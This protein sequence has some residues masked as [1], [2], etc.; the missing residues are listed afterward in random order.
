MLY[1]S[2]KRFDKN[3]DGKLKGAEWQRW[4]QYAYGD[5]IEAKEKRSRANAAAEQK[6]A[7]IAADFADHVSDLINW[8]YRDL[9]H[10]EGE[11]EDQAIRTMHLAL[12]V[13]SA[14]LQTQTIDESMRYLLRAFW[15]EFQPTLDESVYQALCTKQV[16]FAEIGEISEKRLG[17][18]WRNLLDNLPPERRVGK[19]DDLQELLDDTNRLYNYFRDDSAPEID[20]AKEIEPY[21]AAIRLPEE[22]EEAEEYDEDEEPE[23]ESKPWT[24]YY[25]KTGPVGN[26][27]GYYQFCKVQFK[28]GGSP[29]AYLTGG[30][31][32]AVGDFVVVPVGNR[33]AEKTGRVTDV[34]VCAAQ[35]APYPPEKTKFV[36]RKTEQT[37]FPT[38][39]AA[40][41]EAQPEQVQA[42][43]KKP[44]STPPAAA[45]P[46]ADTSKSAEPP[47]PT[48][49]VAEKS[50]PEAP[51]TAAATEPPKEKRR[52]PWG[53]LVA[54]AAVAAFVIFALPPI[55][56]TAEAQRQK[57]IALQAKQKAEREREAKRA[58]QER[59]EEAE[60]AAETA[61][62]REKSLKEQYSGKLPVDGMPVSGLPYTSLG[63][64]TKT[65]K[66]Q[67]YDNMDVHRRYKILHW[68][69][70]E[71]Q[72]IASCHSHQPKG[73]AQEIIYAFTYYENPIG[74][75]NSAA[76]WTPPSTSSSN[77]GSIRDDYD[78]PEDLFE[79]N[80][81]WYDDEDEA[82]DEWENG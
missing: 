42:A 65:E 5:E 6:R 18:F 78:N 48:Q 39:K 52:V 79:D 45:K 46:K 24:D 61:A 62:A 76:A 82:W 81:D 44:I 27:G 41:K 66:C 80:R 9:A 38:K 14:A 53:W 72:V 4:Y 75:P 43:K 2:Q 16:M 12:Y 68:Y 74:R 73:A 29:Y 7:Q 32:L 47:V 67:F 63:A 10:L 56:R 40:K 77:S 70:S 54:A 20:F 13:I 60:R 58:E 36:L 22:P 59:I 3:G 8:M 34:F 51:E 37:A 35:D 64:P 33:N 57:V 30:L 26:S 11:R 23:E 50:E 31:P 71:G 49:P 69:N 28:D 55:K 15:N 19:D 21:W 17:S 1:G 25:K